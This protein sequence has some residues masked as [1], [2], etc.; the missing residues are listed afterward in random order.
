MAYTLL[1]L[2]RLSN[3][4]TLKLKT[5]GDTI[6]YFREQYMNNITK[7][8]YSSAVKGVGLDSMISKFGKVA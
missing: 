3:G 1:E 8:A 4:R 5:I 6:G 2:F 7:F